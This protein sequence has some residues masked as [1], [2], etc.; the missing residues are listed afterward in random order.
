MAMF[1]HGHVAHALVRAASTLVS[2]LGIYTG[3]GRRSH[4]CERGTHECVRHSAGPSH[5][6]LSAGGGAHGIQVRLRDTNVA[7]HS[8]P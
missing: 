6:E 1:A 5:I 7:I 8:G 3:P 2:M 4:D